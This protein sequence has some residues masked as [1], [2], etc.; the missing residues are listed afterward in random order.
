MSLSYLCDKYLILLSSSSRSQYFD[1]ASHLSCPSIRNRR[2]SV[3]CLGTRPYAVPRLMWSFPTLFDIVPYSSCSMALVAAGFSLNGSSHAS[4][5]IFQFL[6]DVLT[7]P[8]P[9]SF[10]LR[11]AV[12][13]CRHSNNHPP[14]F[15]SLKSNLTCSVFNALL[16][17]EKASIRTVL[18][19]PNPFP[20]LFAFKGTFSSFFSSNL[21]IFLGVQFVV[22]VI[23]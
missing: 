6:F 22:W 12:V 21:P 14:S 17:P 4:S 2:Y 20:L 3:H 9:S 10:V 15:L 23:P 8:P 1:V 18:L 5:N 13:S 11:Y 7:S 19:L 16:V